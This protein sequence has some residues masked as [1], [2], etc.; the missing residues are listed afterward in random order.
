MP[1]TP[2]NIFFAN[3]ELDNFFHPSDSCKLEAA[4]TDLFVSAGF[5]INFNGKVKRGNAL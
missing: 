2:R 3:L 4:P 1:D 5:L